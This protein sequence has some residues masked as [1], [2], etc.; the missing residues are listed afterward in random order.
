MKAPLSSPS[1]PSATRSAM[2][3]TTRRRSSRASRPRSPSSRASSRSLRWQAA[4]FAV[5]RSSLACWDAR[6]MAARSRLSFP[7]RTAAMPPGCKRPL[8]P[9]DE[10]RAPDRPA[11]VA[12]LRRE[13]AALVP[14]SPAGGPRRG[15]AVAP[16]R[17]SA[18]ELPAAPVADGAPLSS[19][20][21]PTRRARSCGRPSRATGPRSS[22]NSSASR[23][24]CCRARSARRTR[25]GT[26]AASGS[27]SAGR[28]LQWRPV[29]RAVRIRPA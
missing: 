4:G 23:A 22:S 2:S 27:A 16:A 8:A 29:G 28:R 14:R 26:L 1:R 11:A 6:T 15:R 24:R 21:P 25:F 5:Q 18:R 19:P 10:V 20:M 3:S 17:G 12:A 9:A 7:G 13:Q